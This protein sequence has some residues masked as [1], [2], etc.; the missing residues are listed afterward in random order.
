MFQSLS[1]LKS[2]AQNID[3][4]FTEGVTK[5]MFPSPNANLIETEGF[6]RGCILKR[7]KQED[8]IMT[9]ILKD[10]Y[11]FIGLVGIHRIDTKTPELGIW[12][13][14]AG[15]GYG[16]EA[17]H[18]LVEA[19]DEM[20]DFD[21][22]VYPVDSRNKPSQNIALSLEGVLMS[23]KQEIVSGDKTLEIDTFHI[24]T[25]KGEINHE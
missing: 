4:H 25:L 16:M 18:T 24:P 20:R 7:R 6:V 2:H 17:V 12:I 3:T 13:K 8:M 11:D 22:Y 1:A 9:I 19:F 5:Y 21:Y 23:H 14:E 15:N 10:S